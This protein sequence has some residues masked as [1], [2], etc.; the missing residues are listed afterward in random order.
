MGYLFMHLLVYGIN[1]IN[2][3]NNKQINQASGYNFSCNIGSIQLFPNLLLHVRNRQVSKCYFS[4]GRV[5]NMSFLIKAK[6]EQKCTPCSQSRVHVSLMSCNPAMILVWWHVRL[7][8]TSGKCLGCSPHDTNPCS[9]NMHWTI[10]N[11]LKH[12]G[13]LFH[14]SIGIL[15]IS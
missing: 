2:K 6:L 8:Y 1:I 14:L 7:A 11:I 3:S 15:I 9:Y 12:L 13:I 4:W 5:A 10:G